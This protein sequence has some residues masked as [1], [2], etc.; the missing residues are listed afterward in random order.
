MVRVLP[1]AVS[2]SQGRVSIPRGFLSK[3]RSQE[4]FTAAA[5]TASPLENSMPSLRVTFQVRS[6]T[7][8]APA[9][10]QGS[11]VRSS[12]TLKRVSTMP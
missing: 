2:L 5:S 1:S 3:V 11:G 6:S 7:R 12:P 9:A 8:S 10:S 4:A